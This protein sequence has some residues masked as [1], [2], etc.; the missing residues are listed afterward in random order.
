MGLPARRVG[1]QVEKDLES[2][3]NH[4]VH[5]QDIVAHDGV[6]IIRIT[7]RLAEFEAD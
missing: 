7:Q 6:R 3:R 1:K 5:A 2:L 4:L